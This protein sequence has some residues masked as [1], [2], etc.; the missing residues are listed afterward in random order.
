MK[1]AARLLQSL[2]VALALAQAPARAQSDA[3]HVM[4][5]I[6]YG[7]DDNRDGVITAAE[8]NRYIDKTFKEMDPKG[9]GKV[10][11][12]A[13]RNFSFGLADVAAEQGTTA[14]YERAKDAIFKRWSRKGA[15]AMT[16]EDYRRGVLGDARAA[17]RGKGTDD[18]AEADIRVDLEAFKRAPFVKR[19]I[20][21]LH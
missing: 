12:E 16:L 11:R 2:V 15:S 9:S 10:T 3:E 19:L 5:A 6:F 7:F 18:V 14:K 21:S 1:H 4:D 20:E 8:A 13:F 17:L